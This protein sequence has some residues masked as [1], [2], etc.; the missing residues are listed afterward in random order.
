MRKCQASVW[1][2][3]PVVFEKLN[4]DFYNLQETLQMSTDILDMESVRKSQV[5][6]TCFIS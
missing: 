2:K 1:R 6:F 3:R 4:W 5:T